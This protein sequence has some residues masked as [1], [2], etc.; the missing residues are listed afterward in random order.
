MNN[1]TYCGLPVYYI[2]VLNK[3]VQTF[4]GEYKQFIY[5]AS[6]NIDFSDVG[7]WNASI[8]A[9]LPKYP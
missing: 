3:E 2:S 1:E 9:V 8:T 6:T 5:L 7:V 4:V